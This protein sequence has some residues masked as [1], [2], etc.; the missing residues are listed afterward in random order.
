V[1]IAGAG[2]AEE[3]PKIILVDNF[4]SVTMAIVWRRFVSD[5]GRKFL[6]ISTNITAVLVIFVSVVISTEES[7]PSAVQL[8]WIVISMDT[9]VVLALATGHASIPLYTPP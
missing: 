3:P 4:I 6:Q 9:F 8:L 2:V 1:G 7:D 5:A